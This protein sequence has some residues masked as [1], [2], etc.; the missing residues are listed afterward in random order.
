MDREVGGMSE[1]VVKIDDDLEYPIN[2]SMVNVYFH[3]S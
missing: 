2:N 3:N 1:L